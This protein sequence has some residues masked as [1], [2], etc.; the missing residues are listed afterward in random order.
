MPHLTRGKLT[1]D[2]A[3]R[4]ALHAYCVECGEATIFLGARP[5]AGVEHR[6]GRGIAGPVWSLIQRPAHLA[7]A[8]GLGGV[9]T[10]EQAAAVEA[11]ARA[12]AA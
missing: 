11:R 5:G 6:C 1:V 10:A 9:Q 3:A 7:G 4:E 8:P 12:A 2:Q